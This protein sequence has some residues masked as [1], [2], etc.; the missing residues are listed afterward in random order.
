MDGIA[1]SWYFD[2]QRLAVVREVALVQPHRFM[3]R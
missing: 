1:A 3:T 2:R